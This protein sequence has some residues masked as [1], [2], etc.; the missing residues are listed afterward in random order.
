MGQGGGAP[1]VLGSGPGAQ[2]VRPVLDAH[3]QGGLQQVTYH[4]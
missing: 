1:E 4:I 3:W 2:G